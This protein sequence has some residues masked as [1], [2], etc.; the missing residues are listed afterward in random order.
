MTRIL[1]PSGSR[2]SMTLANGNWLATAASSGSSSAARAP[3]NSSD[4]SDY[5]VVM[6]TAAALAYAS[7]FPDFRTGVT[8]L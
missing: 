7:P 8:F 3:K 6:A 2:G 1:V 5:S 4:S